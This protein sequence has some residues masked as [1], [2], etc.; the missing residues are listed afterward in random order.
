M[1]LYDPSSLPPNAEE[2]DFIQA[3]ENV[4]EKYKGKLYQLG[5]V[6][7]AANPQTAVAMVAF[8]SYPFAAAFKLI[9]GLFLEED[10]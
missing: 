7:T 6:G 3:Y 10:L 4:R 5:S 2:K 1:A 8:R 9:Y